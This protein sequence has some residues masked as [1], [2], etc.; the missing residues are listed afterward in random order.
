MA[1]M[2]DRNNANAPGQMRTPPLIRASD[3]DR[4]ATVLM[5]QD[6]TARGLLTLDEGSNR[7]ASAFA[8]AYLRDLDPLTNDIPPAPAQPAGPPGWRPLLLM[9]G[10]QFRSLL[11]DSSTGQYSRPRIAIAVLLSALL[12][13]LLA[14]GFQ[15]IDVLEGGARPDPGAFGH[16]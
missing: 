14:V 9:V 4:H 15:T 8:A 11:R 5:L 16:H 6:A 13:L 12:V 1:D 3:A 2:A 10:E 7:M